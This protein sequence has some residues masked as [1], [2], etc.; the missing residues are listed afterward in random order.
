VS[1]VS[2]LDELTPLLAVFA[3]VFGLLI[4]SF[5]NVVAWR[6]PRGQSVTNPPSACPACGHRLPWWENIPVVSYLALRGRCSNCRVH[7][8]RVYPIVEASTAA[9]FVL[10]FLRFG[11]TAALPA[12]LYLA[13]VAVVLTLTD[14]EH[15]RLPNAIVLPSYLVVAALLGA[16]AVITGDGG[17][18]VRALVAAAA[19]FAFYFLIAMVYPAG[20]GFGDVK[21]A[22]V[23][24]LG[25]GW[26]GWGALV[27]GGFA[28]FVL[29]AVG[30]LAIARVRGG[31][32]KT[33]IPFGP[34]MLA[35][36]AIGAGWGESLAAAYVGLF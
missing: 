24:G 21:L 1:V 25:L 30:G 29:G 31:D 19:L 7:I 34:F 28:A 17:S 23:I 4:G 10:V 26:V 11:P 14:I 15:G 9:L 5:L 16:A 13:A 33:A 27:V 12:Y 20:M 8:S 36:A 35:G 6:V 18:L 22:G 3:G 2:V 32:R